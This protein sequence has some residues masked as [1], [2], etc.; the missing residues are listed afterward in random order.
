MHPSSTDLP[1]RKPLLL[2]LAALALAGCEKPP[3]SGST[4]SAS[5]SVSYMPPPAPLKEAGPD[6]LALLGVK[7]GDPLGP[8]EVAF[9]AA[10]QNGR[11]VVEVKKGDRKGTLE[12]TLK[13]EKSPLPPAASSKYAVYFASPRGDGPVL[14]SN[15]L[16]AAC[17]GLVAKLRTTEEKSP[18]PAG[19]STYGPAGQAM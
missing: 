13:N 10:P 5:A 12:V 18:T 6:V 16:L 11:I 7:V 4:A 1:R 14:S 15:E 17:E 3:P 8:A 9:V 19:V 2:L